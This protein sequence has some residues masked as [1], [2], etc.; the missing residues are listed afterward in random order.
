MQTNNKKTY[1]G[2]KCS[3]EKSLA[4]DETELSKDLINLNPLRIV[5]QLLKR[6]LLLLPEF[7]LHCL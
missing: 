2:N 4:N 6:N 3:T 1:E 5:K 7:F